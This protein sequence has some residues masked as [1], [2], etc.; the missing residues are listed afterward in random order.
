MKK[1]HL[2]NNPN[3]EK[4]IY[5]IIIESAI[6]VKRI[7]QKYSTLHLFTKALIEH[8]LLRR[9]EQ[10]RKEERDAGGKEPYPVAI[11]RSNYIGPSAVEPM[12]GWVSLY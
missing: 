2:N 5:F 9:I 3:L 6:L 11:F 4:L 7:L 10:V 8:L 12:P 1:V